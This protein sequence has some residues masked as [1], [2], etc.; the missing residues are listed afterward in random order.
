[1]IVDIVMPKM[2][3]SITEGTILEWR[4]SVGDAIKKDEILLE[5]GT[6]KVDSEIPSP[7]SG[8]ITEILAAVNEVVEVGI[9]IA[10][11]ETEADSAV[12]SETVSA[13]EGQKEAVPEPAI[14]K[15]T[16]TPKPLKKAV[17]TGKRFYTPVVL[18]IAA[19]QGL[20]MTTLDTI[21]GTGRNGR[22]TKKDILAFLQK[23]PSKPTPETKPTPPPPTPAMSDRVVEM[24]HIRKRIAEHMRASVDTSA[25]VYVTTEVDMTPI[26]N[27]IRE[28]GPGFK[29]REGFSLTVTPFILKAVIAALQE[30]PEMNASLVDQNIHYHRSINLGMA[31]AVDKGLMVPVIPRAEELNF[32]GLCRRVTDLAVRT[33]AKQISPDELQGSTFSVTNFGVFNVQMG[34]PIINQPNVGILGVGAITKRPVVIETEGADLIGIRS[35]MILSLGFDHRLIDGAGGSRFLDTVRQ[36]LETLDLTHLL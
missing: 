29:A 36:Y 21:A 23:T 22:V 1:M 14:S 12:P 4:K 24:D 20:D 7:H 9:P 34:T 10:R 31:V 16:P 3:E 27:Y 30:F 25:H 28:E 8:I 5:I 19:E 26:V 35:M 13:P 18:K 32:L 33:R 6:D 15:P 2:G 11:L 17:S